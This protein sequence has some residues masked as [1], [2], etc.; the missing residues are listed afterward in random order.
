MR[1]TSCISVLIL[2]AVSTGILED[3]RSASSEGAPLPALL[4]NVKAGG[5]YNSACPPT[6]ETSKKV[7]AASG[8]KL[9]LSPE[10]DQRLREQF[11]SGS[12]SDTLA[13]ALTSQGFV[14]AGSC[15]E[16]PSIR[17]ATFHR[18]GRGLLPYDISAR[19][20]WKVDPQNQIVWTKGFVTYSRL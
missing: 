6:T 14:P 15:Q 19:I 20:F 10:L 3:A 16:E 17:I 9:A 1:V 4:R 18:E 11:P 8:G 13:K 12:S 7:L 2:I 5:G